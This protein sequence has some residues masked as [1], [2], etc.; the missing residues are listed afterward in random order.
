MPYI[1]S[2]LQQ[3]FIS[4]HQLPHLNSCN[5]SRYLKFTLIF[6]LFKLDTLIIF[7]FGALIFISISLFSP[8][9]PYFIQALHLSFQ[10]FSLEPTAFISSFSSLIFH[11]EAFLL[12]FLVIIQDCH[13]FIYFLP[14]SY[15]QFSK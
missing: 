2:L 12:C 6:S 13:H 8:S 15:T 11:F 7:S 3:I 4:F 14:Q 10:T 1:F 5:S 9:Q